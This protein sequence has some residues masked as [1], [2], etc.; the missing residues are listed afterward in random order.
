MG[1]I[2][3]LPEVDSTNEYLN[4]LIRRE[5]CE[6]GAIVVAAYQTNGKG[7]IGN[8]W[9]SET[10]KNLTFSLLLYPTELEISEQFSISK[11]VSLGIVD[12]LQKYTSDISI[13]WPNDIY[14]N[15]KKLG[16]I[17]IENAL[18]GK[19][20]T[21]C[22]VG[23]GLNVNQELFTSNAPN[24]ISLKQITQKEYNLKELLQDL[25]SAIFARYTQF[26]NHEESLY[27]DYFQQLYR[28]K[29]YFLYEAE[30]QT[31]EAKIKCVKLS[32]H[33]VLESK[34]GQEKSFAFKEVRF[35]I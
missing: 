15:D 21:H 17:L 28:N 1:N 6:E 3:F 25:R 34:D 26:L 18:T 9:E 35:V 23:I 14:W 31:F 5:K 33:L 13:K 29:G 20:I 10:G 22:V 7:Q 27:N 4:N 2:L 24:P 30:G 8:A 32:G 12:V 11:A 19:T 16:G